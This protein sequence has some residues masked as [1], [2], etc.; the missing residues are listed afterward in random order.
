MKTPCKY[1]ADAEWW[2]DEQEEIPQEYQDTAE[3]QVSSE[4][5]GGLSVRIWARSHD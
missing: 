1:K 4:W 2:A 3:Y 5:V